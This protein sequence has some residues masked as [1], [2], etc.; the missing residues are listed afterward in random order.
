LKTD[1]IKP[2]MVEALPAR[3]EP[4]EE[5]KVAKP[6]KNMQ[7]VT[8]KKFKINTLDSNHVQP[9]LKKLIE[10]DPKWK[11][12]ENR[13]AAVLRW[14]HPNLPDQEVLDWL[15][16]GSTKMA[17]RYPDIKL[18]A[19]KDIFGRAMTFCTDLDDDAYSFIPPTFQ[20]PD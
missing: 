12:V 5:T 2:Q 15:Q 10:A 18:L 7:G 19:H 16:S 20:L 8:G 6:G 13:N 9:L 17:N 4:E 3:H 1:Q 11:E 14:I